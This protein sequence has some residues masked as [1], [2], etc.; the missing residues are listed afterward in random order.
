MKRRYLEMA[1]VLVCLSL[2]AFADTTV[3][4]PESLEQR[5]LI[6]NRQIIDNVVQGRLTTDEAKQFSDQLGDV[7]ALQANLKSD[8][9]LDATYLEGLSR[10]LDRVGEQLNSVRTRKRVWRGIDPH[11][12]ALERKVA[13][14]LS[15]GRVSK[16]E[17]AGL[18]REQDSL[19]AREAAML[20]SNSS[21][22]NEVM[23]VAND[24]V[25]LEAKLDGKSKRYR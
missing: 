12:T 6:L 22:L 18:Q 23:A 2:P 15:S 5:R 1:M 16:E 24:A 9:A 10:S 3:S 8:K 21:N 13:D 7:L 17:A 11:D 20:E 4:S 25:A 19:K 14:A